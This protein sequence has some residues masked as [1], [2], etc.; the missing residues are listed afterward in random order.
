MGFGHENPEE[1]GDRERGGLSWK[2]GEIP[3]LDLQQLLVQEDHGV[4][5]L[6]LC[7]SGDIA[8]HGQMTEKRADG[9][10]PRAEGLRQS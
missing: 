8:F 6:V 9:I 2:V 10:G 3:D 4:Q 7:C 5:R 1:L